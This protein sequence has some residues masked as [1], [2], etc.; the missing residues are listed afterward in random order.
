ML[1]GDDEIM[2]HWQHGTNALVIDRKEICSKIKESP[3]SL[4][5]IAFQYDKTQRNLE[6]LGN[7]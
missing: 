3:W 1:N 2:K 4:I 6:M 7:R 5:F